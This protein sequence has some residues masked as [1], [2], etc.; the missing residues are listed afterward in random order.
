MLSCKIVEPGMRKFQA[1]GTARR[2]FSS[3]LL[4]NPSLTEEEEHAIKWSAASFYGG[5]LYPVLYILY[6]DHDALG[7]WR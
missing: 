3:A 2:S 1:A 7:S 6:D 4:D 5:A